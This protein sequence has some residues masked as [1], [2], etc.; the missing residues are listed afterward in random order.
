MEI[1]TLVWGTEPH[2]LFTRVTDLDR[3]YGFQ[4]GLEIMR[5]LTIIVASHV[6]LSGPE[7]AV[8]LA[9]DEEELRKRRKRSS[10]IKRRIEEIKVGQ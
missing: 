8:V 7:S 4:S 3:D 6:S 9:L 10:S 5:P 1:K 2:T